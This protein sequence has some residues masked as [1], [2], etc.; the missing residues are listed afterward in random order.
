MVWNL[1]YSAVA[2]AK[3]GISAVVDYDT[4]TGENRSFTYCKDT[5][6]VS[7]LVERR[8]GALEVPVHLLLSRK[9]TVGLLAKETL[10]VQPLTT[11]RPWC[12]QPF[13]TSVSKHIS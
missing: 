8:D 12:H 5:K 1:L 2:A 6:E 4:V 7:P 13:I 10:L 9:N 11:V 3:R